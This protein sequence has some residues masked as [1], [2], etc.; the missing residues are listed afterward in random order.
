[1]IIIFEFCLIQFHAYPGP[2]G[3]FDSHKVIHLKG[4]EYEDVGHKR[5]GRDKI[6][7]N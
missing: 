7:I 3:P 1:M 5:E 2:W 6:T 4:E